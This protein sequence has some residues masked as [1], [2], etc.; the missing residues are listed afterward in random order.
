MYICI[1][2]CATRI[3]SGSTAQTM[4]FMLLIIEEMIR[5]SSCEPDVHNIS[6]LKVLRR[7]IDHKHE[8]AMNRTGMLEQSIHA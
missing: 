3:R 4:V 6:E 7:L 5:R 8:A 1:Y 2:V